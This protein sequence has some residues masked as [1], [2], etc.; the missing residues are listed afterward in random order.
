MGGLA[1]IGSR[2]M[3]VIACKFDK[4][5]PIIFECVE[6]IK[7]HLP[8]AAIC[9]VDSASEDKGYF[10]DLDSFIH[11]L[12]ADNRFFAM[13]AYRIAYREFPNEK[14]FYN[15][16]DSL[17]I[18]NDISFVEIEDLRTIRWWS[19][20][21]VEMGWDTDG[22]N[23]SEWANE[24]MIEH[25]GYGVPSEY[26][27]IFGPMFMCKREVMDN[28]HNTGI[29]NILPTTKNHSCATERIC[30]IVL[31]KLGYNVE[32]SFQ[33]YGGEIYDSYDETKVRKV[34]LLRN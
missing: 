5:R 27:G 31:G 24:Q 6:S 14:F 26:K 20:P 19:Y 2:L 25:L 29:F 11:I 7:R 34:H 1:L 15:I 22:R 28:L 10:N 17:I 12:D 16:H 23:I 8:N 30:G 3:F 21:P 32:N 18:E 4:N 13:E 9:V 33:G